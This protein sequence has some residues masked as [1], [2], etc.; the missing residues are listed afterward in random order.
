MFGFAQTPLFLSV[1]LLYRTPPTSLSLSVTGLQ[2]PRGFY[3]NMVY[4][5]ALE[6]GTMAVPSWTARTSLN[7]SGYAY[8]DGYVAFNTRSATSLVLPAGAPEG[9]FVGL[10]NRGLGGAGFAL[11]GGLPYQV[12]VRIRGAQ[13][14]AGGALARCSLAADA[15][16][17][18]TYLSLC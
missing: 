1:L 6:G 8:V 17:L 5:A 14:T 12:D 9:A 2:T 7:S 3:A 13:H 4:G 18:P 15:C 10:A 16:Y 11:S